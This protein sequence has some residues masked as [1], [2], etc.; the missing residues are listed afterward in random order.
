MSF[1]QLQLDLLIG[2]LLGD[3]F[4]ETNTKGLSCRSWY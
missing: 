3:G 2:T 1:S 4:M